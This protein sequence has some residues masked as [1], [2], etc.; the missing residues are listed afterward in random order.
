MTRMS[1]GLLASKM[2]SLQS[3][4]FNGYHFVEMVLQKKDASPD[5]A[6]EKLKF[7]TFGS[8]ALRFIL[9]Q[10]KTYVLPQSTTEKPGTFY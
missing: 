4:G 9:H 3:Q 7:L 6:L 1:I 10:V 2:A 8:L 5:M